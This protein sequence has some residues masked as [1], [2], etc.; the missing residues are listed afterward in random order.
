MRFI[1]LAILSSALLI[2]VPAAARTG[3]PTQTASAQV[4]QVAEAKAPADEKKICKR[5]AVSG[6]RMAD[7]VCL[8]KEEWKK[9]EEEN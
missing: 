5:L 8:T 6:T 9:V 4:T 3:V 1:P 7:R 2:A